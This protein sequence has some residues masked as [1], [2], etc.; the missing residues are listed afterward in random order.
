MVDG[1]SLSIIDLALLLFI[2]SSFTELRKHV[3]RFMQYL[4]VTSAINSTYSYPTADELKENETCIICHDNMTPTSSKKLDCGH[5]FHVGCIKKWMQKSFTCP[6]CRKPLLNKGYE[7]HEEQEPTYLVTSPNQYSQS[8]T[9][10]QTETNSEEEATGSGTN[11][12]LRQ[13]RS[14]TRVAVE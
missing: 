5:I 4:S 2:N 3:N 12:R 11:S 1:Y 6:V 8:G 13:R 9:A 10:Q 14:G 7:E